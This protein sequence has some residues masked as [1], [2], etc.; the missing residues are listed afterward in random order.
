[1]VAAPRQITIRASSKQRRFLDSR[2]ATVVYQG[3]ARAGKTWAGA[4]KALLLAQAYPHCRG[5]IV[6]P[7]Y[8][9]LRQAVVAE[10]TTLADS[11]G[12][13]HTWQWNKSD[14]EITLPGGGRILLRTASNP[15]SLL[16]AT[17]GWAVGDEVALWSRE[18]YNYLQG[19]LSDPQGPRQVAFTFTPKGTAHWTYSLL[20][21][22]RQGLEVI[23][24]LNRD[25]PSLPEDYFERIDRELGVGS[26]IW[27][28]EALGEYV[29]FEGLVYPQFDGERHVAEPPPDTV[30]ASVIGAVDWGWTNPGSLLVLGMDIEGRI[31]VLDE[32]YETEQ[33]VEWWAAEAAR[34]TRQYKVAQWFCDPS[35]PGNIAAF[36]RAGVPA[37]RALNE[38][39]PGIAAVAGRLQNDTLYV[40][41]CCVHVVSEF[42]SYCWKQTRDG[43]VR[44]D[45]PEKVNDHA[46]DPVRYGVM[47]FLAH[48]PVEAYVL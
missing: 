14:N 44:A 5:M 41:S 10:L 23:R 45:Q 8:P 22:S 11:M 12:L 4:L 34:L 40:R 43:V 24:A 21:Q 15:G 25:N 19:R 39:I 30:W 2:A 37:T 17:L 31:W 42:G 32:V 47:G 36:R 20:S 9:M 28:Q 6:A 1:M 38:V 7:S 18:A 16:G 26:P 3:G 48:R 29:A 33:P 46:M 27:R 13:L 35:E